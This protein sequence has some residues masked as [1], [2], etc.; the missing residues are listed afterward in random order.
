[1]ATLADQ[2]GPVP[3]KERPRW[4]P[5]LN[6]MRH[7]LQAIRASALLIA[8]CPIQAQ[9]AKN[10]GGSTL[11]VARKVRKRLHEPTIK[12]HGCEINDPQQDDGLGEQEP[13]RLAA[14][15]SNPSKIPPTES[16]QCPSSK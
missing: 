15:T 2:F 14:V 11:D 13:P 7:P 5:N 12:V 6:G 1:V 9:K 8:K 10:N 4:L 3:I 16:A